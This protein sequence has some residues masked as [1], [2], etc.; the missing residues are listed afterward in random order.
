MS[1]TTSTITLQSIFTSVKT[2]LESQLTAA[3]QVEAKTV[4]PPFVTFLNWVAA[5][6]SAATNPVTVLPQLSLLQAAVLAAQS[7][8]DSADIAS[9]SAALSGTLSTLI[10]AA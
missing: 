9:V 3:L 1:A 7:N 8:A 10:A 6:P 2:L 4:L 5:N